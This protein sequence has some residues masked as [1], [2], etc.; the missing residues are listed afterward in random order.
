MKRSRGVSASL[1]VVLFPIFFILGTSHAEDIR[2]A[3][4]AGSFYP[5]DGHT[6]E[7]TIDRFSEAAEKSGISTPPVELLRAVIFPH[8][9]YA[10]SGLTA[11]H[12]ALVL[13][14]RKFAKIVLIGP[15]HSV[16]FRNGAVSG[17][18]HYETPLGL[19]KLHPDTAILANK[20]DLFKI[21][22]ASDR[23]EHSLEVIL[24]FLQKYQDAFELV[25]IVLGPGDVGQIAHE[26]QNLLD[27]D[28]LLV[29]SS[30]LSHYLPY[31]A[32]VKRDR[33]TIEM[34][35]DLDIEKLVKRDN[36]A[37]GKMPILVLLALARQYHWEPV[38]LH[39]SNSGD[40][41]G[42]A[43]KVV[44]YSAIAFY[45]NKFMDK[46]RQASQQ[47]TREQGQQ[48]VKLARQTIME[49]LGVESSTE[50]PVSLEPV[51]NDNIFKMHCG[52]FVTLKIADRLRGCIGNLAPSGSVVQG[53]KR[54]A[55]NAATKDYR[56]A[57]LSAEE[58]NRVTIEVSIL[59]KPKPLDYTSAHD[60]VAKLRT[61]VDGV[62]IRKGHASA[63][64]LPQVWDQLPRTED[65]LSHLCRKAGLAA[66]AWK[67]EGLDVQTYQVTYFEEE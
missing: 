38:F 45:G 47:F 11:A 36:S 13:K 25:P 48:L 66:D 26:I 52:T 1:F 67:E 5:S 24:P 34:I 64:F 31:P 55:V 40:T 4:W 59:T 39:Y 7:K 49:H 51:L 42:T 28:S 56:F 57:P 9:G 62:I 6:L 2:K 21:I 10:Y 29:I 54:N 8:A 22:P 41:A 33:E 60:L 35:M 14:N 20:S 58:L 30:D 19:V 32:A 63:T 23:Q 27:R 53:V 16:G 18:N 44:G 65:F 37:C 61:H 12:A 43:D 15:D 50:T 46:Q 3:I 17:A